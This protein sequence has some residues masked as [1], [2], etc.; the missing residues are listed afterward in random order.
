M[1]PALSQL[2]LSV[3]FVTSSAKA[4]PVKAS[5]K[6]NANVDTS[7]FMDVTPYVVAGATKEL[8][9]R[10]NV[11]GCRDS[12]PRSLFLENLIAAS[13]FNARKRVK[14]GGSWASGGGRG[15]KVS[16]SGGGWENVLTNHY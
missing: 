8:R 9:P 16:I 12:P 15:G 2:A 6:A 3:A 5:A 14:N 13:S 4:G 10:P 7:V 11:P 1:P